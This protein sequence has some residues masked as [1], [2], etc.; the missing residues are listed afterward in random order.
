MPEELTRIE[1]TAES[2]AI[3]DRIKSLISVRAGQTQE[4]RLVAYTNKLAQLALKAYQSKVPIDTAE[5]R[6]SDLAILERASRN[7]P[8]A[9]VGI[10]D[11]DH[12]SRHGHVMPAIEL[13]NLLNSNA[14]RRSRVSDA[15]APYSP[16]SGSTAQWITSARQ[17]FGQVKR[18]YD[19]GG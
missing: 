12:T 19:N 13:A 5:L 11:I 4:Q 1:I 9:S 14:F 15:V 2:F 8:Y 3:T 17:A 7:A 10:L 6:D 18:F 16:A